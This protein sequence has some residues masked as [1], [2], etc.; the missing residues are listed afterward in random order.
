MRILLI[1]DNHSRSGGAEH[2][3]FDLKSRLKNVP[4]MEVYS[5]GF[6]NTPESG[7]DYRV[8][9]GLKSKLAKL[10]WQILPHPVMYYRLRKQIESI[11]PDVIHL[12]NIKQYTAS[13]LSAVKPY[14]VVQTVHDYGAVCPTAHNLHKDHQPCPTG[15]RLACFWEHQVKYNLPAYLAL[16]FAF[17]KTQHQ[18]R[19]IVRKFFAPS[20]Q[21]VEYLHRNRFKHCTYIPP[22]KKTVPAVSFHKMN[23]HHFLFAGNLGTHKGIYPM[24]EE[25]AIARQ[26]DP[27]LTLTIAGTGPEEKRMR[28]RSDELGLKQSVF[29]P[30]WQL[31]LE[32]EYEKCAAVIFPSLW[33]EAFGLV[34][35][36]AMSHGRPV[37]GTNR[38][39]P[40]WLID[41][42]KTGI[43]FDPLKKGDLSDKILALAGRPEQIKT[44]GMQAH[45]KLRELIDNEKVLSQI[46]HLYH[47]A[48][49]PA[50]E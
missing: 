25:F 21:L 43:I 45:A 20:P 17:Y 14:P 39:S 11:R 48:L 2:Y 31:Q 13:L 30:G 6:G 1:T 22:F 40:P 38:G 7:K 42:Q 4:G 27:A 18:L 12:H 24:L 15:L 50:S 37:I 3:F 34:I 47:Q 36:E 32:Q 10:V 23:P 35:T 41:D 33:V 19:K 8:F 16:A 26:K 28:Q 49:V 29:F 9:K 44:L 46:I 5:L